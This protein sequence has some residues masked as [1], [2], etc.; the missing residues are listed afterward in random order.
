MTHPDFY[1]TGNE[2]HRLVLELGSAV[3]QTLVQGFAEHLSGIRK[4]V[5]RLSQKQLCMY[6]SLYK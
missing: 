4:P 5:S 3:G 6:S 2:N 1:Q